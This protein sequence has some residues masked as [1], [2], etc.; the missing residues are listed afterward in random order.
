MEGTYDNPES[1]KSSNESSGYIKPEHK[2]SR[3]RRFYY[4]NKEFILWSAVAV[5]AMKN[6]SLRS[7]LRIAEKKIKENKEFIEKAKVQLEALSLFDQAFGP[8]RIHSKH[9]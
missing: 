3:I 2:S 1:W 6:A 7:D 4:E 9:T 5:L 8:R